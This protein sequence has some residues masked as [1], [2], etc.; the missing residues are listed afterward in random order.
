MSILRETLIRLLKVAIGGM[1]I[2]GGILWVK[3][4]LD[5]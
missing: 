1:A 3:E 4:G 5:L 2:A